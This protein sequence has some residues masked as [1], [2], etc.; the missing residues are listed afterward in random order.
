[1]VHVVLS[2]YWY[3]ESTKGALGP[4]A[5]AVRISSPGVKL[6]HLDDLVHVEYLEYQVR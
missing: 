6:A 4:P 3:V 2:T 5:S 1:M